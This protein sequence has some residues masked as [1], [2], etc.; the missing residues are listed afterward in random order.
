MEK[1]TKSFVFIFLII[2]L[3][4]L[5]IYAKNDRCSYAIE[6]LAT[7]P[8]TVY[9]PVRYWQNCSKP[10]T[11]IPSGGGTLNWYLTNMPAEIPT[12]I[13]PT[14]ITTSV[15]STTTYYVSQ[16]I[17]SI[18]SIRVPI[19][20]IVEADSGAT[21]LN[22]KCDSSQIP[23]YSLNYTPPA[24]I[25][26]SVLF[27]WS[28]N[29]AFI[30]QTYVCTYSIQGG[31]SV[32]EFNPN[33]E[34]HFIVTNLLP[35]QSVE[36]TLTSASHP[37]V[38]S[39]KMK[40][41]VS[42]GASTVT[43]TF[44]PILTT[45]CL[46]EA[47]P[48]LPNSTNSPQITG[49]WN[50]LTIDTSTLGTTEYIFTP[51]PILFPCATTRMLSV[52]VELIEPDF[53]DLVV[54]SGGVVPD[55]ST[56]TTSPN[57]ITGSWLPLVIDNTTNGSYVFTTD[58]NQCAT[59]S[60][61][62]NVTV[63]PSNTLINVDWT[64]TDAFVDNQIITVLATLAGNYL[65]QLDFGAFQTSPV[66]NNVSSGLHSITV[67]DAN[68]CS[69]PITINNVLV[70]GYPRFFT[71]NGDNYN[72]TWNIDG[73]KDQTA[74]IIR[75]FDR[76][77]KFLKEISPTGNGWDGIYNGQSMPSTDYWF[78]VDYADQNGFK[79]FKSHFSLKR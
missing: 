21:I 72:D 18:E 57:G 3:C 65:Y 40:C 41:I 7:A 73:L 1:F 15:G 39:Q 67:K 50:P 12:V 53:T 19:V 23:A 31:A 54:C 56:N 60:K 63:N 9:S 75:I 17:A 70:I 44:S 59:A 11:A 24:T 13:A 68:G 66:F 34:S 77:G 30:S 74:S 28:N 10:L 5:S 46:N 37:C 4:D 14:P 8:P 49:T 35:G 61:T 47:P 36:L 48:A 42:C 25:N 2:I 79:K 55:L 69:S 27:D 38:P 26:N 62:I 16:T 43:P 20:V 58:P 51:D 32:T 64:V 29:N 78:V 6:S 33:N 76:Y 52:T 22:F 45:Y 71:P